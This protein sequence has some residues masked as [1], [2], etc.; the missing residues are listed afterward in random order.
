METKGYLEM[1]KNGINP[2]EDTTNYIAKFL[3]TEKC[4]YKCKH[5]DQ[6]ELMKE[7]ELTLEEISM[8]TKLFLSIGIKRVKL[9][10][11]TYGEP[12]LRKD[13]INIIKTVK[14]SG[15]DK[16]GL[17]T[18]GHGLSRN[19]VRDLSL[20]GLTWITIS[21]PTLDKIKYKSFTGIEL[22]DDLLNSIKESKSLNR[23]Q[24]NTVLM[25]DIN[26]DSKSYKELINFAH[27]NGANIHFI[28]LIKNNYKDDFFNQHYVTGDIIKAYLL[29]ECY[30]Y[31]Y[32]KIMMTHHYYL[33]SGL[34]SVKQTNRE[35]Y[36]CEFCNRFFVSSNGKIWFCNKNN[37]IGDIRNKNKS[38]INKG[39]L[40]NIIENRMNDNVRNAEMQRLAFGCLACCDGSGDDVN[41]IT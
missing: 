34:V 2:V 8:I 10:G 22:D 17:A 12:L 14:N 1:K 35:H 6:S 3:V 23:Y 20:A 40:K 29:S 13:I 15:I 9:G 28:E 11:G 30:E 38:L 33:P 41:Q 19:F 32:N 21:I 18:N 27:S 39:N 16:I 5:C 25:R 24:I 36:A 37:V 4:N 26:D 31:R 7:E